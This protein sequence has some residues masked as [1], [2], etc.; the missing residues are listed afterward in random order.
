MCLIH[1]IS[2]KPL[3]DLACGSARHRAIPN[4]MVVRAGA[5]NLST[6]SIEASSGSLSP[7]SIAGIGRLTFVA[8]NSPVVLELLQRETEGGVVYLNRRG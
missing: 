6:S 7:Y 8:P 4:E 3:Q 1:L 5:L 2:A